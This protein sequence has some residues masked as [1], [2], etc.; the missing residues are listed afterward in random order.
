MIVMICD[1][2]DY[3]RIYRF[4]T[5]NPGKTQFMFLRE[6]NNFDSQGFPHNITETQWDKDGNFVEKSI[7]SVIKVEL[8]PSIPDEVFQLS[9][10]V[11]YV[12]NDPRP[13][14]KRP[15]NVDYLT[16]EDVDKVLAQVDK[17]YHEKDL[18]ALK[19]FLKHK[20]WK[21][22]DSALGL[23]TGVAQGEELKEIAESVLKEDKSEQVREHAKRI[24]ERIKNSEKQNVQE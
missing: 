2:K 1:R 4:E 10:P 20:S 5:Q 17:A 18:T 14:E 24:L 16:S 12:V 8:N 7:Y 11:G 21:V 3:S 23:I 22:R 6:C 13:P 9:P 15:K 19:E